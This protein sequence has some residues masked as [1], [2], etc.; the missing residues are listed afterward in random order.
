MTTTVT[1]PVPLMERAKIH[2]VKRHSTLKAVI[3]A[4]LTAYLDRQ[5]E[6]R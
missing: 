6:D 4:A 5:K 2:A 1:L 3:I